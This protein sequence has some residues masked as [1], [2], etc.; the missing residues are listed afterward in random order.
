ME[1][2]KNSQ[3]ATF[4]VYIPKQYMYVWKYIHDNKQMNTFV[5]MTRRATWSN[6]HFRFG[7]LWRKRLYESTSLLSRGNSVHGACHCQVK[8]IQVPSGLYVFF[9][10]ETFFVRYIYVESLQNIIH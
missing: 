10:F 5:F 2:L 7:V 4:I 6:T 8:I 1:V 9:F 3:H